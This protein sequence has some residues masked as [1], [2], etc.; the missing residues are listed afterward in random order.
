MKSNQFNITITPDMLHSMVRGMI[1]HEN[2]DVV[3][4]V[5]VNHLD[6]FAVEQLYR[7]IHGIAPKVNAHVGQTCLLPVKKLCGWKYDVKHQVDKIDLIQGQY[8][9]CTI[10]EVDPYKRYPIKVEY[11]LYKD[12]GVLV[13]DNISLAEDELIIEK[14]D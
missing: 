3:T 1:E 2:G 6:D 4:D 5:I 7:A 12:D 14:Y 9:S 11:Q 10:V 8:V 13:T